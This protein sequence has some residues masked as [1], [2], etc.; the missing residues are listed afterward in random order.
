[1]SNN[2]TVQY[3][4]AEKLMLCRQKDRLHQMILQEGTL[5]YLSFLCLVVHYSKNVVSVYLSRIMPFCWQ[6]T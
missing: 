5:E 4:N 3:S 2:R 1:M 6:C